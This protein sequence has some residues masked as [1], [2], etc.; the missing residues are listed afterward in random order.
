MNS[1][2]PKQC[3]RKKRRKSR[4]WLLPL[5][6]CKEFFVSCYQFLALAAGVSG[7]GSGIPSGTY[8][9]LAY[10]KCYCYIF[11]YLHIFSFCHN[12]NK[13]YCGMKLQKQFMSL[14]CFM[15]HFL[16]H[17]TSYIKTTQIFSIHLLQRVNGSLE[18]QYQF[19]VP[20]S[21]KVGLVC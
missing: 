2:I 1:R 13:R 15:S 17:Q 3:T 20:K 9:F 7:S 8:K 11:R 16:I 10:N 6:N 5:V 4:I 18:T 14:F 12:E 21:V 19:R